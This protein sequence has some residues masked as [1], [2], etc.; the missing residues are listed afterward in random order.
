MK[1]YRNNLFSM[2]KSDAEYISKKQDKIQLVS[3]PR[4]DLKCTDHLSFINANYKQS[5]I[6]YIEKDYQRS[7]ETLK[8]AFYKTIDLDDHSCHKC[9]ELFRFTIIESIKDIHCELEKLSTGFWGN[10]HY[11]QSFKMAEEVLKEIENHEIHKTFHLKKEQ[12]RYFP[13]QSV[14]KVI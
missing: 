13:N 11:V 12:V 5:E 2:P 7:I 3:C 9:A 4:D 1:A 6:F 10:K 8:N 14:K